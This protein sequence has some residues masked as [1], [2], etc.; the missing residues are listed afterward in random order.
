MADPRHHR[1]RELLEPIRTAQNELATLQREVAA[2]PFP[3]A[4]L[5]GPDGDVRVS[6][7]FGEHDDLVLSFQHGNGL[8]LLHVVG[9]RGE[10]G[11]RGHQPR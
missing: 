9:R 6:E 1:V 2:G 7:L 3:D 5:R 4:V 10:R 8:R 11:F